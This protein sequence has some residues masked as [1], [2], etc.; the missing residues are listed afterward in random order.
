MSLRARVASTLGSARGRL[1]LVLLLAAA[2]RVLLLVHGDAVVRPHGDENYYLRIGGSVAQ[3]LGHPGSFRPPLYPLMIG[4]GFALFGE[5]ATVVRWIQIALS[6]VAVWLVWAICRERFSERGAVVSA[7]ACALSPALAHFTHF[8]WSETLFVTLFLLFLWMLRRFDD[9]ER[10][11]TLIG[12]GLALALA[13]LTKEVAVFFGILALPWFFLRGERRRRDAS[14]HALIFLVCFVLPLVPW[15]LRNRN[16]HGT[17]VGLS[18]CRWFP[19]ATGNLRV[20]DALFGTNE[21]ERFVAEWRRMSNAVEKEVE[22]E[23]FSRR[24]ALRS[25]RVQ[26][27]WW[28]LHKLRFNLPRLFSPKGQEIRFLELGLYP[29]SVGTATARAYVTLALLGHLLLLTPGLMALWL[30]RGDPLKWLVLLMIAYNLGV[31]VV[32]NATPRFLVPLLPL[33]YLYVGPWL[34][35]PSRESERWRR[36]GAVA[37]A[38]VFVLIVLFRV[39]QDLGPAWNA[40]GRG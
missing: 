16:L 15:A 28:I 26:Q 1:V 40:V 17:F 13:A 18:T 29:P 21:R 8:L 25:I 24:E 37:T 11:A 10:T 23:A 4:A 27:P 3:G 30:V 14:R 32:A 12:A 31:Y 33:F 5:D 19:I 20:E 36:V 9:D 7:L 6:L 2:L 34:L 38:V 22:R 39:P 35:E